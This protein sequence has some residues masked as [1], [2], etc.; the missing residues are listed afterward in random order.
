MPVTLQTMKQSL[1]LVSVTLRGLQQ[2]SLEL[3]SVTLRGLQQTLRLQSQ[4]N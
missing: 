1:E 4:A 3:V 2:T